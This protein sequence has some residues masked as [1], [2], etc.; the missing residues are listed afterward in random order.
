MHYKKK[1]VELRKNTLAI[2]GLLLPDPNILP[3]PFPSDITDKCV[4]VPGTDL[5]FRSKVS[6]NSLIGS[7]TPQLTTYFEC[8]QYAFEKYG[9]R[10]C[11]S[12]RK[13]DYSTHQALQSYTSL[14][15][16]EVG[17]ISRN[18]GSGLLAALSLQNDSMVTEHLRNYADYDANY[19]SPIVSIFS[20]NRHE[21]TMTDIACQCFSLTN[22]ALYDNLGEN[23][24]VHV[25]RQTNSPVVV[26]SGDKINKLYEMK[27]NHSLPISVIVSFDPITQDARK[28]LGSLDVRLY[29]FQ[30]IINLGKEA[31]YEFCPPSPKTIFSI[32][33]TSGTTGSN[34]KGV[35]LNHR[36]AVSAITFLLGVIP[37]VPDAKVFIF[38]PL[39][40]IYE[41]QTSSF[42]L[43]SGFNLG[44]PRLT[45]LDAAVD[46]FHNLIE[47]LKLFKP[48]YFSIVPRVLIKFESY[49]KNYIEQQP[50]SSRLKE[51]IQNRMREQSLA[52]GNMGSQV[53]FSAYTKLRSIIGFDNLLWTQ[54]AS[55]PVNPQTLSYLKAALGIGI[56]QLYGLTETFGA[57]T[58]SLNY[59]AHP[60]SCGAVAPTCEIKLLEHRDLNYLTS[61]NKGEVLVRGP[62]VFQGYYRNEE[63]TKNA[64]DAEGWFHTGDVGSVVDEKLYIIDRVKNFFKL[65][66]GEY[67]SPE[68]IE[69]LYLTK[70]LAVQQMFV[71]GNS[72]QHFVVAIV[73]ISRETGASF[74]GKDGSED[75]IIRAMNSLPNRV[76]FLAH[77]NANMKGQLNGIQKVRNLRIYVNPLTVERRVITPTMKIMR[78]LAAKFF[79]LSLDAMYEEGPLNAM[80]L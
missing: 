38:L 19:L 71:Y 66:Q 13:L 80:K 29:E 11:L 45:H 7:L 68:H 1:A 55:A 24:S 63:E 15:Y 18:L 32:S 8:C 30:E 33:F 61:E 77:M 42:A 58:K 43:I 57:M 40:H 4:R 75:E 12:F 64:F 54:T 69:N 60:G 50:E 22:T 52:D 5:V 21:W 48:H 73:G 27:K 6:P 25:L 51:I 3:L 49:L 39:T 26:C 37:Q 41:R 46:A 65:S 79:K 78:P 2:M 67:I 44:Y 70:N 16:E 20:A 9:P 53:S 76:K 35:L 23:V 28:K 31:R 72:R 36:C 56:S 34:P 10:P 62:Q 47:D 59:E 74:L 17:N 14:T